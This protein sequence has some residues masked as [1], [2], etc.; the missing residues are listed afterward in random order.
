MENDAAT[1]KADGNYLQK[2][3]Y[4]LIK[5]D[6]SVFDFIQES[7]L[8]GL[9]YWDLENPENEW[10][11]PR[12]WITLGYDPT[13]M[14]HKS[15]AWQDIINPDDLKVATEN[16]ILHCNNPDHPYD[17]IVRYRHKY[18]TTVWIRCR[19]KAIRDAHG[20][21][22][23]MLGAHV[24]ISAIKNA[25]ERLSN[26]RL[27]LRIIIDKIPDV[28]Y[29]KDI[30][31]RKILANKADYTNCGF[32]SE[33]EL[34]GKS[35]FDVYPK[36][37]AEQFFANDQKILKQEETVL[38]RLEKLTKKNG[39]SVWLKSTKLPLHNNEGECIGMIGI[40]RDITHEKEAEDKLILS[41]KTHR[42]IF[43]SVEDA[44]FIHDI[45]TGDILDVND[46]MLQMYGYTRAELPGLSVEK[47]SA[48]V[49]PYTSDEAF[50]MITK[51]AAG[52]MVV[53]EWLNRKKNG[54]LFYTENIL[55]FITIA[56]TE[57]IL[58]IV[59]NITERKRSELQLRESETKLRNIIDSSPVAF[60]IYDL[61]KDERLI[62]SMFNKA[63]D[64]ILHV[65]H[66]QFLG[67][68]I[69]EAF[70][71]LTGTEIPEMYKAIA[72]GKTGIQKF[73]APYNHENI[74]GTFEVTVFQSATRQVVVNFTDISIRKQAEHSTNIRL[75]LFEFASAHSLEDLLRKALDETGKVTQS[76]I[77]FY[78]FLDDNQQTLTLQAWSTRTSQEFCN[79][80]GMAGMHYPVGKA[81]VWAD[82]VK[83]KRA[84]VHND[85]KSLALKKG[86][87]A[88]HAEVIREL[89][90]PVIRDDKVVAILG[91]GNK[92]FNYTDSDV[93]L[94]SYI[95]DVTWEIIA[96]KQAEQEIVE[97][98]EKAVESEKKTHQLY[99]ELQTSEEEIR[100]SNEELSA[101]NDALV[102]S[103]TELEQAKAKVQESEEVF[104]SLLQT[105]P[106]I[107]IKT[108][109]KGCISFANEQAFRVSGNISKEDFY[110]RNLLSFVAPEDALRASENLQQMLHQHPG[111]IEYKFCMDGINLF[112]AELNG[113]VI[114]NNK[115]KP[116]GMVF[117]IRDIT[118]RKQMELQRHEKDILEEK[119]AVAEESLKFKQNFLANMSHEIRTPLTGVLGMIDILEQTNLSEV[120]KD[121]LD[122]IKTSGEN[123]RE[124][125]NQVLDYSKIE[126]GKISIN[127]D[128]MSFK[129]LLGNAVSLYK[130]TVNADVR[131]RYL[132]DPKIPNYIVADKLRLSQVLNN[133]VSNAVKFT[134]QGS[135]HIKSS[136]VSIDAKKTNVIIKIEVSDSGIGIAKD[137][138]EKLFV[139]FSQ[140]EAIDTRHYE[141]TGLGLSICRQL[142]DMMGGQT[143]LLSEEGRGSTFWF[144]FPAQIAEAHQAIIRET[145]KPVSDKPLRIL[146]AEDK[147]VNQKVIT[148]ILKSMGHTVE[149]AG[150]G[151]QAIEQFE[152]G[153]FDLILMDIQ[154]PVMDGIAAA[155]M[156]KQTFTNL[157]PIVGLSANAFEGDREKYMDQGMDDYLTK[158]IKK[159]DF[160]ELMFRLQGIHT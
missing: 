25:E 57:R 15:N 147:L 8:D 19:G 121:Y 74:N 158:P 84:I 144:T 89:V 34:I 71:A 116:L 135:I 20:K 2:E 41:E 32:N 140:I 18:G 33:E 60:H 114:R 143:G 83:E 79:I 65:Q 127:P 73:E 53:F 134:S 46:T 45:N 153:R 106:D 49:E 142:I 4:E 156:L 31:A 61:D 112:D 26:E 69:T 136:L 6:E 124:I 123:L 13:Q 109:V 77:G 115:G 86:L 64:T 54:E 30:N 160:F 90:V 97:A 155:K 108:D 100:A 118:E 151:K 48:L 56:G 104:R 148:L 157:P 81:G 63:A 91:I 119:V 78:H 28:I 99:Y 102:Q 14:P 23:R 137:L 128:V 58:A 17:Q 52:Q 146:L 154:M 38:N 141:G 145:S 85:Y 152:P 42:E 39:E 149:V 113:E 139:P 75:S 125:I 35:D 51:A 66:R 96:R 95:A 10:M 9:W 110:G 47:I 62:F 37:I 43:N 44:L 87:P 29:V 120:Q 27:L 92:P 129:S 122:T 5:T 105:V 117:S 3:L 82:C 130:N 101:I 133:Y 159:T 132:L 111:V 72:Q 55:K 1:S 98:R 107:I 24:D 126:A 22:I 12:F 150:N 16:F 88:G 103:L 68:E 94:V 93:E 7:S 36:E 131:L 11:N 76:P 40:G 50:R 21:P 138:Q 59:R 80:K 70:P 67:L